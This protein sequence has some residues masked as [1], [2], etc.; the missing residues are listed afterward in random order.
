MTDFEWFVGASSGTTRAVLDYM[1]EPNVML[2]Y[3]TRLSRPWNGIDRLF[4]DSGGFS[5]ISRQGGHDP[6]WEYANHVAR[7]DADLV[8]LQDLPCEDEALDACDRSVDEQVH[9]ST[10]QQ[11]E[12]KRAMDAMNDFDPELVPVIQGW[13]PDDYLRSIEDLESA[14]LDLTGRVGVGTLCRRNA[15]DDIRRVIMAI[16]SVLG[17]EVELHGFGVKTNVLQYAE[18]RNLL[19]SADSQSYNDRARNALH[20]DESRLS[21]RQETAYQYLKQ[22]REVLG[23]FDQDADDDQQ[24]TLSAQAE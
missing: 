20:H 7:T 10:R 24:T 12:T 21:T 22:K 5:L 15:K 1:D 11:A 2:S 18:V 23:Y 6:A 19:T 16:D 8:A 17:D 13:E 3:A 9:A 14:G 4:V